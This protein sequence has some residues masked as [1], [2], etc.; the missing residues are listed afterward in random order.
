MQTDVSE[1]M[2]GWIN[3]TCKH[4]SFFYHVSYHTCSTWFLPL[5]FAGGA[6]SGVGCVW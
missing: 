2:Y 3:V 4:F 5:K 6:R 1:L